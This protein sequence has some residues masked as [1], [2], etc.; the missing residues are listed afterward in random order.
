MHPIIHPTIRSFTHPHGWMD[1][2]TD[3]RTDG[4]TVGWMN[5][6]MDGWMGR[7]VGG[8]VGGWMGEWVDGWLDG[9]A[10]GCMERV[11]EKNGWMD[12]I[13]MIRRKIR[14]RVIEGG[15]GGCGFGKDEELPES[16][17]NIRTETVGKRIWEGGA[18][19]E[20]R[21]PMWI[22]IIFRKTEP[23][24]NRHRCRRQHWRPLALH[25]DYYPWAKAIYR[26]IL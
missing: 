17:L 8:Y 12:V 3:G 15:S 7:L 18:V 10:G 9:W 24:L 6:W 19:N 25:V 13:C 22:N 4:W 2:W 11:D 5:G 1:G 26:T 20:R 16:Q 23:Y 21:C 14:R